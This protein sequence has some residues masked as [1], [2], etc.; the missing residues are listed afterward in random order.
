MVNNILGVYARMKKKRSALIACRG[1]ARVTILLFFV[2]FFFGI[3]Y[4]PG[5]CL[6]KKRGKRKKK[7]GK[8]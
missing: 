3:N 6:W 1:K 5:D 7:K 4:A 8:L 2:I